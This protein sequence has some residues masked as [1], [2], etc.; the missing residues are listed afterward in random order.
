MSLSGR[1]IGQTYVVGVLVPT[2]EVTIGIERKLE[3]KAVAAARD[4]ISP[5]FVP[6]GLKHLPKL[7]LHIARAHTLGEDVSTRGVDN[8]P[9]ANERNARG[10]KIDGISNC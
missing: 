2:I 8:A 4:A 3:Q 5:V 10:R 1:T 7:S 9:K 6:V